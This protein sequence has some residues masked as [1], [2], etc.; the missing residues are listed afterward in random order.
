MDAVV[1]FVIATTIS[2]IL[3][4]CARSETSESPQG[5][6]D[7][8]M[9]PGAI[10]QVFLHA[11]IGR[12]IV[13]EIDGEVHVSG[14]SEVGECINLE[15]EALAEGVSI[16]DFSPLNEELI[17]VLDRMCS[18][19]A[20]PFLVAMQLTDDT[21]NQIFS[22]PCNLA[23]HP[24]SYAS[25][26]QLPG[27]DGSTFVLILVLVPA[28]FSEVVDI[29]CGQLDLGSGVPQPSANLQPR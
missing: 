26:A 9:D 27:I 22:L 6:R 11:S 4:C 24:V 3:V 19:C 2:S 21:V 25:S 20:Q 8:Q 13:L 16:D 28:P 23:D 7:S 15:L 5:I 12:E 18:P 14:T 29:G 1:F 10:L 17:R